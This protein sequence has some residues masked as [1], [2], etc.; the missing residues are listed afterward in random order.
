MRR[1]VLLVILMGCIFAVATSLFEKA[2]TNEVETPAPTT[3]TTIRVHRSTGVPTPPTVESRVEPGIK[4]P[5]AEAD[6]FSRIIIIP[7]Q[8]V[9]VAHIRNSFDETRGSDRKHEATDIIAPKG[10]PVL[11]VDDGTIEKLFFSEA[12]GIT[13]YQFDPTKQY[14]YYYAHLD[15]YADT[16]R[17]GMTVKRGDVIGYVGTTGNAPPQTPHLHFG[18]FKLDPDKRW[19]HGT[20]LNPYPL[21]INQAQQDIH[22]Q[23]DLPQ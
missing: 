20:P 11:A 10:A 9:S 12:G 7:V 3:E 16:I 18:I 23:S 19:W 6:V 13:L 14:S 21:L 4:S 5:L 1:V 15:R 2:E 17:E 8:G 22:A